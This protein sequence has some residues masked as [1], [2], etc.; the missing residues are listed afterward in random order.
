MTSITRYSGEPVPLIDRAGGEDLPKFYAE[1]E[2]SYRVSVSPGAMRVIRD[3]IR[4]NGRYTE[5]GGWLFGDSN[6]IVLATG[7]GD[8][9]GSVGHSRVLLGFDSWHLVRD[10]AP[11]L[12]PVGDWHVHPGADTT[13]SLTDR[14][15]W[16]R[17][18][19]LTGSHWLGLVFAPPA[20]MWAQAECASFITF[21]AKAAMGCEPLRLVEL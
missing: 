11:H 5:T 18:C 1:L 12:T 21:G 13:P 7:P 14:R 15:A 3:E 6:S 16:Q 4:R 20:D 10:L 19:E 9:G 2:P 8:D 17:G